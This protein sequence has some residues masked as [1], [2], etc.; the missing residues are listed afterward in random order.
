[1]LVLERDEL[2]LIECRN[3]EM[4]YM[5]A[6]GG[7]EYKVYEIECAILRLKR[8][9]ELIQARKN[10]QE[11][12]VISKIDD[13]LDTEFAEYQARLD[14]RIDKMNAALERSRG[15]FLTE[16]ETREL[17]KLYRAI[18]KAL[19]PDL[20]PRLSAAKAQLFLNAASAYENGDI[21]G[22]RLISV[23]L[24]EPVL[25]ASSPDAM[26]GLLKERD[27]LSELLQT[28]QEGIAEIKAQYPYTMKSVIESPEKTAARQAELEESIKR[29]NETLA[30]YAARVE[31]MII[32]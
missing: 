6:I 19:H 5:L 11:K 30:A 15:K 16:E 22:L 24:A 23:M 3:I 18:V 32:V 17:K 14:E 28:V 10:R 25:P 2:L 9:I 1:M 4:A 20:H 29:L 13:L 27:R 7:L 31:Q 8:K 21:N 26:S 12:V